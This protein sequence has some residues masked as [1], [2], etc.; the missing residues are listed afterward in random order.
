MENIYFYALS[1]FL[2]IPL[3]IRKRSIIN[4]SYTANAGQ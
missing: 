4:G 3:K 1:N 2:K